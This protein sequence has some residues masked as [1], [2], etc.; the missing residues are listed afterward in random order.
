MRDTILI[1]EDDEMICQESWMHC[2]YVTGK[3]M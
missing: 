3:R 1:V 2:S